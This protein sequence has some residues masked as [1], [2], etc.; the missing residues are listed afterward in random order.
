MQNQD[1]SAR[2]STRKEHQEQVFESSGTPGTS[3]RE[4]LSLDLRT[5]A[6]TSPWLLHGLPS[7]RCPRLRLPG[8]H[9]GSYEL[10]GTLLASSQIPVI[11]GS[12]PSWAPSQRIS[13]G[14]YLEGG[15]NRPENSQPRPLSSFRLGTS[16][17]IA[18]PRPA[19]LHAHLPEHSRTLA[20]LCFVST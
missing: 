9:A 16:K 5:S 17:R 8:S 18:K 2:R 15:P 10:A 14:R 12:E 20:P 13:V 1:P 7:G 6:N 19:S 3:L 11:S 4:L